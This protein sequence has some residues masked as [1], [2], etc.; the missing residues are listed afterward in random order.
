[1]TMSPSPRGV[2]APATDTQPQPAAR[3]RS[4][5]YGTWRGR[6][7]L[8]LVGARRGEGAVVWSGLAIPAAYE[9]DV[10][11]SGPVCNIQG[12]LE[13]DFARL[14]TH[15]LAGPIQAGG[16]RLRLD[17]GYEIAID[18]VELGPWF[19]D[20]SAAAASADAAAIVKRD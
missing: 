1:M 5:S 4:G 9:L 15:G 3:G 20:F 17:D 19:A 8:R 16:V 7:R 12:N 6:D 10:F 11:A 14:R 2:D 13:G 18:L